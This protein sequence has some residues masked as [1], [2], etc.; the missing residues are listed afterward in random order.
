MV[1]HTTLRVAKT[2]TMTTAKGAYQY[3]PI[4]MA[5]IRLIDHSTIVSY[6]LNALSSDCRHDKIDTRSIVFSFRLTVLEILY[7]IG[8]TISG[9]R[10]V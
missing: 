5:N 10:I 6:L 7:P 2:G 8:Y 3:V 1:N 4:S 9:K